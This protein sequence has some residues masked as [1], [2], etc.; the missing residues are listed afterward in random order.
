MQTSPAQVG[1]PRTTL[2]RARMTRLLLQVQE[3]DGAVYAI[4]VD[5]SASHATETAVIV[6]L[7]PSDRICVR[8]HLRTEQVFDRRFATLDNPEGRPS[9]AIVVVVRTL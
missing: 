5:V 1:M 4:A 7:Q 8:G 2:H 6:A 9:S 3:E